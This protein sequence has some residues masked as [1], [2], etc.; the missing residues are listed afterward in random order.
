MKRRLS[1]G[2]FFRVTATWMGLL[3]LLEEVS[4]T[5]SLTLKT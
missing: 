1:Q 3:L 5:Y 4:L 2:N